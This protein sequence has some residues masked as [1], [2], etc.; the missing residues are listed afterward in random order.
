[1]R[2]KKT[3]RKRRKSHQTDYGKRLKLL[4]AE[5]PRLVFRKTNSAVIV[6][7]VTSEA[8]QDTVVF[9]VTSKALLK[10]G[11]PETFKGSLKSIPAAYL[12]GFLVAKKIA[13][14]KLDTPIIDLGMQRTLYKTRVYAFIKGLIDAGLEVNCKEE[15]FPEDERIAGANMKEDF[16]K[17]FE[18]IKSKLEKQ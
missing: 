13:K 15:A 14:E 4:K 18:T 7:Y 16:T 8:A 6:Q 1:M 10:H 2:M 17:T 5:R 9:G 11:W 3:I 12:T